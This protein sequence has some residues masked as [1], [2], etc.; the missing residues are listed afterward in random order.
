MPLD[1]AQIFDADLVR[2]DSNVWLPQRSDGTGYPSD[3]FARGPLLG[4]IKGA[5]DLSSLSPELEALAASWPARYYLSAERSTL[6]RAFDFDRSSTVME[7]GSGCGSITRLLGETFDAVVGVEGEVHRAAVGAARSRDQDNVA[8][9]CAPFQQLIPIEP[10]GI[11]FCVGVLE[12]SAMSSTADDPIHEMLTN[13]RSR[14]A[15]DGA[16]VLA[17]E[18]KFGLKYLSGAAEDHTGVRFDGIEGYRGSGTNGPRTLGR[19]EL[20]Q[21]LRKAG[22]EGVE[23]YFPFPDYKFVRSVVAEKA[24]S[25]AGPQLAELISQQVATDYSSYPKSPLFNQ[26]AAWHEAERNG[27]VPDLANSFL[28]VASP[29]ATQSRVTA[30]WDIAAFNMTPRRP[31]Y[32]ASTRVTGL[33]SATPTVTRERMTQLPQR[34]GPVSMTESSSESWIIG[35]S[36]SQLASDAAMARSATT[37]SVAL[38]LSPWL[39]HLRANRDSSGKLPAS[40]LDATP[41]NVIVDEGQTTT[42][43]DREWSWHAPLS[44]ESVVV[45]GLVMFYVRARDT[46]GLQGELAKKSVAKLVIETA[47]HLGVQ[48]SRTHLDDY[49]TIQEKVLRQVQDY[50]GSKSRMLRSMFLSSTTRGAVVQGQRTVDLARR[51]ARRGRRIARQAVKR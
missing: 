37:K 12:Y 16:L 21:A 3:D 47:G 36:T 27:L 40:F 7:I 17:I 13:L 34:P 9:V 23:F 39:E 1:L 24:A 26:R 5:D 14:V 42:Y 19:V 22:F 46:G 29:A 32:W 6:L 50:S 48:L 51:A 2:N 30:P 45:R 43:I 38:A 49:V 18:N 28:V 31:E 25:T 33:G 10:F 8:I 20:E 35:E 44:L 41:G 4:L 15:D 11:V